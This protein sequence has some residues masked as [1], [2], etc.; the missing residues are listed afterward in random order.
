MAYIPKEHEKY[1]VLPMCRREGG[2]VFSYPSRQIEELGKK[3]PDDENMIPYGY[4]SMEEY[5]QRMEEYAARYFTLESDKQ[6]FVE[7]KTLMEEMNRKEEWSIVRYI[8]ESDDNLFGLTHGHTYYWPCSKSNPKYE[9]VID[10]EEFTSY[11]YSTEP[12]DWEILLDPTGM[13][14]ATIYGES[15]EHTTRK[16]YEKVMEQIEHILN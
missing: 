14:Y 16:L 11:W 2:E 3:L 10:D 12:E 4:R 7:F 5:M 9:G 1:D 15:K 8:G 6:L 13:A